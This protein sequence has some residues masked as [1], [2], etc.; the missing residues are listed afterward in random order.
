M[1]EESKNSNLISKTNSGFPEYLDFEKLRREGIDHLGRLGGKLWTDH[2]VHDPGITI[3]EVL[4]YALLDLGYRTNLPETDILTRNPEDK[5]KDDNFFTPASIL[6]CNPL[7]IID[8]RK[9]LIDIEGV[10]NAWLEIARDE[11]DI[12]RQSNSIDIR[13]EPS[14]LDFLNGL[15]HVYIDLEKDVEKEFRNEPEAKKEYVDNILE[16][17]KAALMAHRNLCEDFVDIFIL[18]KQEVGV[19]ADIELE[20]GADV[21]KVYISVVE[22]LRDFFSP[23]PKFYTLQQLLDKK[24][25][26][27]EIYAG[28]PYGIEESHGFVDTTELELLKL[29]KEIHLSDVYN[30]LFK[31]DGVRNVRDLRLQSCKDNVATTLGGWKYHIPKNHIP[32]FSVTCSGFQF[33]RYRMP[34][35]A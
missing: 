14:C 31:V 9:L 25:A 26:I 12:C 13:N 4:C 6:S 35:S 20:D 34:S 15:Y 28:R 16:K 30:V 5:S 29:R 22:T 27:E 1:S 32:E 24:K 8:F 10:K 18:C 11:K 2:N 19:C 17:I 23:A 7:T 21:E 3:L 33:S